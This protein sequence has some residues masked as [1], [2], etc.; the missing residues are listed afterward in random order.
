MTHFDFYGRFRVE[1]DGDAEVIDQLRK[2][3]ERFSVDEDG[4]SPDMVIEVAPGPPDPD[5]VLGGDEVYYGRQGDRFVIQE[6]RPMYMLVRE[7]WR[8]VQTSPGNIHHHLAYLVEFEVRKRLLEDG[9]AMV[10]ASGV[11]RNGR[12]TLFPAWRHAG[13]TN[14]MLSLLS[15]GA[16]YLSD[17]RVWC[18][19]DG[20]VDGYPLPINVMTWNNDMI[21]FDPDLT[22]QERLRKEVSE[23]IL[24]RVDMNRSV[25]DKVASLATKQF[26]ALDTRYRLLPL[27]AL[28]PST[29]YVPSST[30]DEMVFLR[31]SLDTPYNEVVVEEIEPAEAHA[32]LRQISYWEW[33][34]RLRDYFGSFDMLFPGANRLD[35]LDALLAGE[36]RIFAGLVESVDVYRAHIPRERDWDTTGIAAQIR[37]KIPPK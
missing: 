6:G 13:K 5:A 9:K 23:F 25:V 31:T 12:T 18:D 29:S 20:N 34:R 11:R 17:D 7:D 14:T 22:K 1:V 10:H 8:H 2:T 15:D 26:V 37:R 35:E 27:E 24:D 32:D 3:Y 28:F 16:D 30:V 4:T 19:T 21:G 33:N 36:E